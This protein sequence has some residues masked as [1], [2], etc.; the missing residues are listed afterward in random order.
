MKKLGEKVRFK[1]EKV[2]VMINMDMMLRK[3]HW[4]WG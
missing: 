4:Q 3:T 1:K 2:R